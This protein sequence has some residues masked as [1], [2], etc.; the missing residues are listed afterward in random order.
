[1]ATTTGNLRRYLDE[2]GR[3]PLLSAEEET[4]CA[5]RAES[6]DGTARQR[7]VTANL[8]LVVSIARSYPARDCD[9]HDLIQEGTV[10]LVQAVDKFDWRR[11]T[12]LSTYAAPWIRSGIMKALNASMH[13]I[14]LPEGVRA[15]LRLVRA[16]EMRLAGELGRMPSTA[17]LARSIGLTPSQIQT[18]QAAGVWVS[19]LD[20]PL[21]RDGHGRYA[22]RLVDANALDPLEM[23]VG[24]Q[25]VIDLDET[26]GQ[27]PDRARQILELRLGLRDGVTRTTEAVAVEL[28]LARQRVR[29]IELT[30]LRRLASNLCAA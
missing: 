26:L 22:D 2:I 14:R 18:A 8:R 12:R 10:G 16:T 13:P 30:A 25:P 19:S 23:L 5:Q 11:G 27:L 9:L 15:R 6:G 4:E 7:L 20:E 1:M 3:C 28:G 24:D 29:Q 17:E 21:G